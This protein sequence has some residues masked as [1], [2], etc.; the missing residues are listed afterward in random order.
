M[1]YPIG[2]QKFDKI[3]RDGYVYVD[4]TELIY[5]LAATG[6]YYFLSR[7]RR[8]GK[9]LLV[10]TMEAY[11]RGKR[12]LFEGLAIEK[13]EKNWYEY[14]VIHLDLSG[15]SYKL[16]DSLE[17]VLDEK[18]LF[19]EKE[20][21]VN[22]TSDMHSLRFQRII[23]SAY[24]KFGRQV[25]ILIDE[26]DKPIIDNLL[27]E[28]LQEEFRVALQGFYSVMKSMDGKI[29]FGFLTG[30]TKIGKLSVFSGLNNL[31]D[32]SMN[33]AYVD[34]C[35]ISEEDLH[36][37]FNES[38]KEL[39]SSNNLSEDE[40]YCKL[41]EMY[42][43]YHFCEDSVGV[44]NPFSILNT[45]KVNKFKEYWFETGTPTFM[46]DVIKK[47]NFDVTTLSNQSMDST[48]L[49]SVD[50]VFENPVPLLFQSGYLTIT[51]YNE[52]FGL[53]HLSFPN[54]EVKNGFLNFLLKYYTPLEGQSGSTLIYT[55]WKAVQDGKPETFM[56]TLD[57]LFAR[58]N[59][60]IQG[61]AE[62]D[63][64]YAMYLILELLGEHVQTEY[65]TS[66]GRI[67]ILMQAK[68]YIYIF[69]LKINSTAEI[70]LQQI[71][72][73]GYQRAFTSDHRPI[74]KI[75]VSFSTKERRIED[76]KVVKC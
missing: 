35:G 28:D 66:N 27:N 70:A 44:Y 6:C 19:L 41:K 64:Q 20:F 5:N 60:Q 12:E 16:P 25:V 45:F 62:R 1:L 9:S 11:F 55:L 3:R 18:L 73:K 32:I 58:T 38:V 46:V 49:S 17:K 47:T 14:P 34:I 24:K 48:L 39:A 67:D 56:Q 68:G 59:Y 53:Y 52:Q 69:E 2:I 57:S 63:F 37:Y 7:P 43:G 51:D 61:N 75:G 54:T 74:F 76:W 71:D 15:V 8:F 13:L 40:C 21:D 31:Q 72:E 50:S 36:H 30:V 26:Y 22:R 29:K 33:A 23:D 42:D 65:H 10:S 4:K